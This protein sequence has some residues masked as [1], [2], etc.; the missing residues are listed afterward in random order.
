[1]PI[2]TPLPST[3]LSR[4]LRPARTQAR[5]LR[6][7]DLGGRNVRERRAAPQFQRRAERR[8]GGLRCVIELTPSLLGEPLELMDVEVALAHHEP[9][10]L[11]LVSEPLGDQDP[12]ALLPQRPPQPADVPPPDLAGALRCA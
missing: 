2:A 3:T 9:V 8:H 1:R 6:V 4:P 10:A 12:S 5:L 7:H 11:R